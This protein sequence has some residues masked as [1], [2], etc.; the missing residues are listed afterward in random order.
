MTT[1]ATLNGN[2][3]VTGGE[4]CDQRGFDYGYSSGSYSSSWTESGS[5]TTGTF[6]HQIEE[7]A[8]ERLIYFRAKAHNSAGWGYGAELSFI[9]PPPS[10]LQ[11][12][13]RPDIPR[14]VL[15]VIADYYTLKTEPVARARLPEAEP[16]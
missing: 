10:Q 5:F 4:N 15:K 9:T 6:S 11:L 8:Y 1:K 14:E 16:V 7:P 13:K 12:T 3:T 2:I